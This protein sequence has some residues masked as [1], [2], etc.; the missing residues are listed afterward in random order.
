MNNIKRLMLMAAAAVL[1]TAFSA[2]SGQNEKTAADVSVP[3][4]SI[5]AEKAAL[6]AAKKQ[7]KASADTNTNAKA[8]D[9]LKPAQSSPVSESSQTVNENKSAQKPRAG[10]AQE[11]TKAPETENKI[12][13]VSREKA[14]A[15]QVKEQPAEEI[16]QKPKES[17]APG[18]ASG[19]DDSIRQKE[20]SLPQQSGNPEKTEKP[21]KTPEPSK[22]EK[23]NV[24]DK[25]VSQQ[26]KE[27]SAQEK[28]QEKPEDR[29]ESYSGILIDEDCSD[30]EAPEEHDLPCMLMYSC[31]D[32]GYGLDILQEDGTYKF[33]MFDSAGQEL[34]W[35]YLNKTTRMCGLYVTVTG[36]YEDGVIKVKTLR[37]S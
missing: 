37:E 14:A 22:S 34:A 20:A 12:V 11:E 28:P 24:T 1:I 33:Y 25:T 8:A 31:R 13:T 35:E 6:P 27:S 32:S 2:C 3:Q 36:I 16:A 17:S 7:T 18:E 26:E 9:S 4:N 23:E 30:F 19:R 15:P 21:V 29:T 10:S 5:T